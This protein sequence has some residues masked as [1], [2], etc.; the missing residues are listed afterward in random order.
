MEWRQPRWA[1][2]GLFYFIGHGRRDRG[3]ERQRGPNGYLLAVLNLDRLGCGR[4]GDRM[5]VSMKVSVKV[6]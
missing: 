3:D 6:S 4:C 1:A 5:K 2:P